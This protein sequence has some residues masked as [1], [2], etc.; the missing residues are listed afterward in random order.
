M[1]KIR[2]FEDSKY[3][4]KFL[5]VIIR[6]IYISYRRIAQFFLCCYKQIMLFVMK[7]QK[8]VFHSKA[9]QFIMITNLFMHHL[10]LLKYEQNLNLKKEVQESTM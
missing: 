10:K 6:S 7:N 8:P 5:S 9:G 2:Y 4:N 1:P 3:E